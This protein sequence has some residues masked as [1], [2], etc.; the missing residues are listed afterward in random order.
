[1]TDLYVSQDGTDIRICKK[2]EDGRERCVCCVGLMGDYDDNEEPTKETLAEW[3]YFARLF[4]Q[5][6][7]MNEALAELV[8]CKDLWDRI[9]G[10]E[11]ESPEEMIE[12]IDEYGRRKPEA[13]RRARA[14]LAELSETNDER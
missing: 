2:D 13:W 7:K 5:A 3:R 8:A 9:E 14:V 1:M 6:E 11:V 12:T 10:S 4:A